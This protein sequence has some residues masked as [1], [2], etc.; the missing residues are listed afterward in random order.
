MT[1]RPTSGPDAFFAAG[2]SALSGRT[3]VHVLLE[4][5]DILEVIGDVFEDEGDVLEEMR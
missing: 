1:P 2:H 3:W 5:I 4:V